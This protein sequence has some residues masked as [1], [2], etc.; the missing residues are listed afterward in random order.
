[1]KLWIKHEELPYEYQAY[2][3]STKQILFMMLVPNVS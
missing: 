3:I 1:M 2:D